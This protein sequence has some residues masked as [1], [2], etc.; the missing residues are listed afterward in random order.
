[1]IDKGSL[2]V[3]SISFMTTSMINDLENR[4]SLLI[5]VSTIMVKGSIQISIVAH[6][7]LAL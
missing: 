4:I 5:N 1:M 7:S 2:I 3:S 6:I